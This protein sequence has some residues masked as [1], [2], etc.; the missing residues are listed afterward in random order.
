MGAKEV[1]DTG[2]NLKGSWLAQR[3][4]NN[5]KKSLKRFELVLQSHVISENKALW[6]FVGWSKANWRASN[7]YMALSV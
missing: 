2:G 7:K 1:Y 3:V 6:W 4:R 5:N